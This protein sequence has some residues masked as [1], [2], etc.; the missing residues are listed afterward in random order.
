[1]EEENYEEY[2]EFK[3]NVALSKYFETVF[4]LQRQMLELKE[5]SSIDNIQNI[6]SQEVL[7]ANLTPIQ[8]KNLNVIFDYIGELQNY[9]LQEAISPF[10]IKAFGFLNLSRSRGGF[11]QEKFTEQ[12]V[13]QELKVNQQK[14]NRRWFKNG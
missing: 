14:K 8:E 10:L 2:P 9:G 13:K 5:N 1:M 7:I 6:F 3:Q 4:E 11:Q 12:T